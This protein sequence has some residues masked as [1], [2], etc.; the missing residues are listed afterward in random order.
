MVTYFLLCLFFFPQQ[1]PTLTPCLVCIAML[2]LFLK[3][4]ENGVCRFLQLCKRTFEGNCDI[5]I[6]II[7]TCERE[8]PP[9]S[10]LP[11]YDD[12]MWYKKP[13]RCHHPWETFCWMVKET[14]GTIFTPSRCH[15]WKPV[16]STL[17]GTQTGTATKLWCHLIFWSLTTSPQ[18]LRTQPLEQQGQYPALTAL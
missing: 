10:K 13:I 14:E 7:T 1:V 6:I 12:A 17:G 3:M 4:A 9:A 2:L 11:T 5:F 15:C 8:H 18:N 16:T